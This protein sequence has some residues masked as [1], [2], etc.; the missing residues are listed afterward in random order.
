MTIKP[1]TLR[2]QDGEVTDFDT[3]MDLYLEQYRDELQY[4]RK[5]QKEYGHDPGLEEQARG[6]AHIEEMVDLAR[7]IYQ[8][9]VDNAIKQAA[10]KMRE[11]GDANLKEIAEALEKQDF[12]RLAL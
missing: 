3:A 9:I 5:L 11:H 10:Q 12:S 7:G 4:A 6:V 8:E 2:F 1:A